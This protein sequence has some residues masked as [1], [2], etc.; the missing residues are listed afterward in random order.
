M[1]LRMMLGY[2]RKLKSFVWRRKN[3]TKGMKEELVSSFA[4]A[5]LC[6][7]DFCS[8]ITIMLVPVNVCILWQQT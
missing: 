8:V 5:L 4:V 2:R 3:P 1:I 6:C 7:F